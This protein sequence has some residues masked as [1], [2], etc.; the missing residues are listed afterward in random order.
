MKY[1]TA[2]IMLA[3]TLTTVGLSISMASPASAAPPG[4]RASQSGNGATAYCYTSASG[5]QF[6]AVARCRYLTP[7]GSF[8]Y[9]NFF[10]PWRVQGNPQS[11]YAPCGAGWNFVEPNARTK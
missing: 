6:R 5:T 1:R 7:S 11:S 8:D 2:K 4:C 3:A 9:E 10:G